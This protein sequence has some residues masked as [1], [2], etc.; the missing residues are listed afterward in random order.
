VRR[1]TPADAPALAALAERTFRDTFAA[2]N[3]AMDMD[4][5]CARAFGAEI[6]RAEIADPSTVTLLAEEQGALAGYAQLRWA[7][8][9]HPLANVRAVH[10]LEV[11]RFYVAAA[12]HGR[13]VA[14]ALM[15]ESM[16]IAR[17]G[18][19]DAMWLGVWER[20][21]RAI[22]FYGKLGFV[23]CG[24]QTFV[25]GSDPQRDLV[26]VRPLAG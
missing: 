2:D 10:P 11:M 3:T 5:H 21:P 15:A 19:A 14:Q 4:L 22:R 17:A 13:G 8:P 18:G 20:N 6:Q 26:M 12:H 23:T 16:A 7:G 24:E 25:L 9:E 1:A